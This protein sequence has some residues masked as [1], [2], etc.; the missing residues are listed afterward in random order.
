MIKI[1]KLARKIRIK[2]QTPCSISVLYC[3]GIVIGEN[4]IDLEMLW[5]W[6]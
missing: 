3:S 5:N 6:L 1:I 2:V 4:M